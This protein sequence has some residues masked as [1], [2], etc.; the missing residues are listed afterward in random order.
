M[1]IKKLILKLFLQ[2]KVKKP[3]NKKEINKILFI[4]NLKIGDAVVSFPL[5][6]ELKKNFPNAEIDVYASTNSDFLFKK[7]TY[8]KNIFTKFRKKYFYKT[9]KQILFMRSRR[10]DLVVEA[11]PMKFGLEL[12]VWWMKPR[13]VI[14]FGKSNGDQKLGISRDELTFYDKLEIGDRKEHA[15]EHLCRILNLLD[16]NDYSTKMEFPFDKEKY[17]YAQ[18]FISKFPKKTTG[19]AGIIA[20]NVD[21]SNNKS[22][23]HKEQIIKYANSLKD[24]TLVILSLPSRQKEINDIILSEELSNCILSYS[25][26]TIFDAAELIRACDLLISPDTSFI[27]IAPAIDLPTIGLYYKDNFNY[28]GPK[29]NINYVVTTGDDGKSNATKGIDFDKISK[30]VKEIYMKLEKDVNDN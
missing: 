7:L 10:Y 2:E 13:W 1:L 16:I 30:Y 3:I 20:L 6:R 24:Y 12:S 29:S 23:L 9:W 8:C 28:W 19:G 14:G 18:E 26:K 21:A 4:R 27:H 25:T 11:V 5:L 17:S 15:S 22:T